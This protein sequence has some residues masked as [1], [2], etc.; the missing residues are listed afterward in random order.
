[1]KLKPVVLPAVRP[2]RGRVPFSS[3]VKDAVAKIVAGLCS[4]VGT[5][6]LVFQ[7]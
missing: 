3:V 1:M 6:N 5:R 2:L 7:L 4:F